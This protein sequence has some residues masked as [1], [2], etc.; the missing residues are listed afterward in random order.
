MQRSLQS[1]TLLLFL[2]L[3]LTLGGCFHHHRHHRGNCGQPCSMQSADCQKCAQKCQTPCPD[4]PCKAAP[5]AES[6][7]VK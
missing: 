1:L 2:A 7:P 4:C 3:T 5:A 6:A